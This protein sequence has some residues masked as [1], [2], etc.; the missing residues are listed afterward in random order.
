M[1]ILGN[2]YRDVITEFTGVAT[3]VVKYI[4]GCNQV[5]LSPQVG[6]DGA[7]RDPQWFDEQRLQPVD[8][9][10]IELNNSATPGF[11]RAA[12]VR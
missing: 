11:D 8:G 2:R 3:G 10:R 6:P 4:S 1:E 12:P 9:A 5:L 7:L